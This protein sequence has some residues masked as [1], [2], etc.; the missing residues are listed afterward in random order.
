MARS[1]LGADLAAPVKVAT[2][3]RQQSA[4]TLLAVSPAIIRAAEY[5]GLSVEPPVAA[6]AAARPVRS[7]ARNHNE[8]N[9]QVDIR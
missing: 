8:M 5:K 1:S 6:R 9:S 3:N 7:G 2:D 4:L